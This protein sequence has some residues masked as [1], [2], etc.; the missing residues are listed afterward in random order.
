MAEEQAAGPRDERA[1]RIRDVRAHLVGQL[2]QL[3]DRENVFLRRL[4]HHLLVRVDGPPVQVLQANGRVSPY[5]GPHDQ[6]PTKS[7]GRTPLMTASSATGAAK[8]TLAL[9]VLLA[10][11]V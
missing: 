6:Q 10:R 2:A 7:T 4:E 8:L 9:A 3:R 11:H 1:R 5:S